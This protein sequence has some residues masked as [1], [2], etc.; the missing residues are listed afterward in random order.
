MHKANFMVLTLLMVCQKIEVHLKKV[1]L[2]MPTN[3]RL[4]MTIEKFYKGLFQQ[5]VPTF[6]KELRQ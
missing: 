6:V 3:C 4:L 5:T 2:A 1:H